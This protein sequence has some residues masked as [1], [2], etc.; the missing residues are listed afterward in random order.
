[1]NNEQKSFRPLVSSWLSFSERLASRTSLKWLILLLLPVMVLLR[2]PVEQF[3]YDMWW[4]MALGK[5]YLMHHTM[6]VDHSIFSWTPANPGWIYNTWLGSII[7][8][9]IYH[10]CGGFG[11]WIL[12][13]LVF[14]S[15]F[16]FICSFFRVIRQP[17][18]V[19]GITLIAALA[20]TSANSCSYYKP[21]LFSITLSCLLGVISLYVKITRRT[22]LLYL[23]PLIFVIWVNLHGGFIFGFCFLACFFFGELLN[24][25]FF[26][27]ESFA[28]TITEFVHLGIACCLALAATLLN[29]YGFDYLLN[30]YHGLTSEAY[31]LN[32]TYIQAYVPLWTY[33]KN[34][35]NNDLI[36][37]NMG[38]TF[39]IMIVMMSF[40]ICLLLHEFI[41][42]RTVDFTGLIV[43]VATFWA[44]M[45]ATRTNYMFPLMFF[46]TFYY[47]LYH[48]K[49]QR[50]TAKATIF[51]LIVFVVLFFNTA[52]FTLRYGVDN[53]WFGSGLDSFAPVEEVAFLKKYHLEGEIFNDYL[54][55][56]YLLW[57]LYPEYKVFID[58]RHVPY[59]RQVAPD[60]WDFVSK[61]ATAEDIADFNRRYPF[62]TAMIH[63][64]E[65]PLIFDFLKAGWRLIYFEKNAAVLIHPS[66]FF[67]IPPDVQLVDLGPMRFQD[68]K[69]PYVL[70]GV[71]TL[72]VNLNPQASLV[73][74]DIY[75][76]NV[77]DCYKPK[78]E[79]LKVM[80]DDIRQK[81]L[82]L[83][84]KS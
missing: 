32:S 39:W 22:F 80:E 21:E 65:M 66:M 26:S 81:Q 46:F 74:Y 5:Y 17:L 76:R 31:D 84:P 70:L 16:L 8:Y 49:I 1:M 36:F 4:Q 13:W 67:R 58:P 48:M 79:H 72:Y 9:F 43:N 83:R 47:Q 51:S 37:F 30:I 38:V 45:R 27:R 82:Q 62:Q 59:S 18:D 56:G 11:L 12:Q 77:S 64:R 24:I 29:P 75:K 52:Y 68:V 40:Q 60:Y 44:S 54:I 33:F 50:I 78:T 10:F 25:I 19:T 2:Y 14:L 15:L 57:D 28:L 63:Y 71:F 53:K 61:P 23:Y 7:I 35:G 73:I 6:T 42:R 20:L 41:T 55:G 69:N 34:I 3:D